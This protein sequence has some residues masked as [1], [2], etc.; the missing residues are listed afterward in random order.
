MGLGRTKETC[1]LI[2]VLDHQSCEQ[3]VWSED[4]SVVTV[5]RE[6]ELTISYRCLSS[7]RSR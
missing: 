7:T 3:Q 1:L 6:V 4:Q 5:N 2:S